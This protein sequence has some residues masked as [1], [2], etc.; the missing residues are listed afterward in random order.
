MVAAVVGTMSSTPL[1]A[2][3]SRNLPTLTIGL[4]DYGNVPLD[5]L[6]NAQGDVVEVYH[7]VGVEVAWHTT[8]H[9][10]TTKLPAAIPF[11]GLTLIILSPDM[12]ARMDP[13]SKALGAATGD[14][15]GPGHIAYVFYSRLPIKSVET[16]DRTLGFVMAHEIGHLLLR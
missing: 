14:V 9:L 10:S 5:Q 12:V 2:P 11:A 6:I 13:P 7:D 15:T 3:P 1:A 4:H 16:D 8:R